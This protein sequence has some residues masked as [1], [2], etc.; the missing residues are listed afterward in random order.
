MYGTV[1]VKLLNFGS[2]WRVSFGLFTLGI[3]WKVEWKFAVE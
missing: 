3:H 1:E 2:K